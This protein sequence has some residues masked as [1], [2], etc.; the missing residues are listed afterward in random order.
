MIV[1]THNRGRSMRRLLESLDRCVGDESL[2]VVVVL[3]GCDDD[4]EALVSGHRLVRPV[5]QSQ[6]GLAAARNAGA[7]NARS[8]LLWFVDDDMEVTA[9]A[10]ACHG[11]PVPAREIRIGPAHP[12]PGFDV[13]AARFYERRHRRLSAIGVIDDPFDFS[14]ANT[15]MAAASFAELGGYDP[16]LRTYGGEDYEFAHRALR[17]G[18]RLRFDGGAGV[19]HHGYKPLGKRLEEKRSS[20]RNRASLVAIHPDLAPRVH[21]DLTAGRHRRLL[22]ALGGRRPRLLDRYRR[23]V[24]AAAVR[25]DR[26]VPGAGRIGSLANDAAQVA[27]FVEGQEGLRRESGT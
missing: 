4:T 16:S 3:D 18:F 9:E 6:Q 2:E 24:R 13:H 12:G 1:P 25:V 8:D 14:G 17:A 22:L 10:V 21:A 26:R 15:S 20:W 27:G 11:R 7:A 23:A 5:V 19:V